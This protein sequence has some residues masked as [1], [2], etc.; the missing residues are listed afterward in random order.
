MIWYT[1]RKLLVDKKNHWEWYENE[2]KMFWRM[3][4]MFPDI[5][6]EKTRSADYTVMRSTFIREL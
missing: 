1:K 3:A 5:K 6:K 4:S 2:I